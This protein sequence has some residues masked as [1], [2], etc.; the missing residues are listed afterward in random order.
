M[1]IRANVVQIIRRPEGQAQEKTHIEGRHVQISYNS[2]GRFVVRV[3]QDGGDVLLV[4][5]ELAS[6]KIIQFAQEA[7]A[8]RTPVPF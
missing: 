6:R 1:T 3:L 7:L 2:D 5:S 4:F 8:S